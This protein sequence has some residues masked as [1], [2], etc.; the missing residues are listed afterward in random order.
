MKDSILHLVAFFSQKLTLAKC[1]YKI[2]NK[3]L[4]AIINALEQW[5]L[6]LKGTELL[7]QVLTN[8]KALKYFMSLKKLTQCQA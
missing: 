5:R 2:Y 8:Y 4:L 7:I 1:N 3:E 6:E